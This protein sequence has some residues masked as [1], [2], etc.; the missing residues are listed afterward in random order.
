MKQKI[1][2]IFIV[3]MMANFLMAQ[4]HATERIIANPLNLSYR[5]QTEGVCRREAADPVIVLFN[6]NY[7]LFASHSSGYWYS[8]NLKDWNYI[9]TK[10][11][12]TV[13]NWAPAVFVY[14]EA[15]YHLSMGDKRIYKSTNPEADQWEVVGDAPDKY[16]DPAFFQDNDGRV[17]LYYGCS[18][19]N[20]IQ[21]VEVDP[22]NGFK[23]V[24]QEADLIPHNAER[25]GWEVFGDKNEIYDKKGWNEAPCITRQG[26]YYYL[27]YAAPGTEFTSY[28]TGIYVSKSPLGPY[29]CMPGAPFS[30]KP[31]GFITGA[32]HG[33]PFKDH[34]GNDWY[35]GTMIVA[36]KDHYER[37]IGI[38]PAYYKSGIAHAI[39]DYTDFPFILP[40]KKVDFSKVDLSAGMNL[41]SYGRSMKASSSFPNYGVE[42]ATDENIKTIWSAATGKQRE[43]LQMDL[44][45]PMEVSALQIC[46]A[47]EGFQTYRRD[48][49]VPIYQYVVEYSADGTQWKLMVDRSDNTQDQIYELIPLEKSV[50]ARFVRVRNTKDF[51]VGRFSIAD[52]RLF[53][54]AKGKKPEVV[55]NFKV[56]RND[57]R[58]RI[59]F[60][61]D[62]VSSASGYV[63]RWGTEPGKLG[64]A[65]M[66]HDNEAEFGFFDRDLSYYVTIEAFGDTGKGKCT[67][68]IKI[69]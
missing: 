34:Y 29:Q 45:R 5:F 7:Y 8:E 12:K 19:S 24:G 10:T 2:L 58:R 20:P 41:L 53:G 51:Q 28:C 22:E 69:N 33:H 40:D 42:N 67:L 64:N 38:F 52:M 21:G 47:D 15:I 65:A 43:W 13:E 55:S 9:K 35:V 25:L 4:R 11:L 49:D 62:K 16:G 54:K 56:K 50:Q 1:T 30:I 48:R 59:A 3:L 14:K 23:V 27:Q 37:R 63:I 36:G 61:W 68:P 46:F 17:Y 6:G 66:V 18:D 31:G 57:D 26:D 44:G 39:T 32:G 60:S